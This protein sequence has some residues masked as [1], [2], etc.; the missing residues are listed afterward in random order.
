MMMMM[1]MIWCQ[2]FTQTNFC[3]IY[4][5]KVPFHPSQPTS[6]LNSTTTLY[7]CS[8]VYVYMFWS[9]C[10]FLMLWP[11]IILF[12]RWCQKDKSEKCCVWPCRRRSWITRSLRV[13]T[14]SSRFFMRS[15]RASMLTLCVWLD[16]CASSLVVAFN[17]FNAHMMSFVCQITN[18][19]VKRQNEIFFMRERESTSTFDNPVASIAVAVY[20]F[21]FCCLFFV[22]LFV[23]ANE[24]ICICILY[25]W[26][27]AVELYA[28]SSSI[29]E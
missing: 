27:S 26:E 15:W 17:S 22:G 13:A 18:K 1:M 24:Y 14:S 23:C 10:G 19:K 4:V 29:S 8:A 6:L 2:P 11:G 21:I 20:F 12:C 7:K 16:S 25:I 28:K 9:S 5:L 3:E